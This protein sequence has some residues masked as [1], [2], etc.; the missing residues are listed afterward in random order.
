MN[1]TDKEKSELY[2]WIVLLSSSIRELEKLIKSP[3][4]KIKDIFE[5][6]NNLVEI[7]LAGDAENSSEHVY[8]S[9]HREQV[10]AA[11]SDIFSMSHDFPEIPGYEYLPFLES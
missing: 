4:V 2:D 6:H 1:A 11:F 5:R 9:A 10:A 7:L 3:S 8:F